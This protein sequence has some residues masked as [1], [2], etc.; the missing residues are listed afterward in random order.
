ML[1]TL[2]KQSLALSLRKGVVLLD[3]MLPKL[4]CRLVI[5]YQ[6]LRKGV[7]L[8]DL[9]NRLYTYFFTNYK[10]QFLRKGPFEGL[11]RREEGG[12]RRDLAFPGFYTNTHCERKRSISAFLE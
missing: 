3:L 11:G 1:L 7:V 12:G 6:S 2:A 5:R 9:W 4:I 10:Y 8:L